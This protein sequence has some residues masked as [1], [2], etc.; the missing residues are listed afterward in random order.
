MS[1]KS[2]QP[3]GA[4]EKIVSSKLVAPCLCFRVDNIFIAMEIR[5]VSCRLFFSEY[6]YMM[7]CFIFRCGGR[8][9]HHE[10]ISALSRI[11]KVKEVN[12]QWHCMVIWYMS[13]QKCF[14]FFQMLLK[15][16]NKA[17]LCPWRSLKQGRA[18]Q[19]WAWTWLPPAQ[20]RQKCGCAGKTWLEAAV[21][22]WRAPDRGCS[23]MRA[24]V[25]CTVDTG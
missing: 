18:A 23:A 15:E 12:L 21:R 4:R 8:E 24:G 14:L 1:F 13:Y 17:C 11:N 7:N 19:G 16:C 20:W 22:R 3:R 5:Y 9:R 10:A 6:N 25:Q 2:L